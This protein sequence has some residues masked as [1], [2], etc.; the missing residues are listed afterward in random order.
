MKNLAQGYNKKSILIISV[1]FL[2]GLVGFITVS[3]N[4]ELL[5]LFCLGCL[6]ILIAVRPFFGLI[7]SIPLVMWFSYT[8]LLWISAWNYILAFLIYLCI[9]ILVKKQKIIISKYSQRILLLFILF[10]FLT[11]I[12]NWTNGISFNSTILIAAKL[13]S[14][15]LL[16]FCTM[17]FIKNEKQLKFFLY[18]L[19][20]CMSISALVGIGQFLDIDFFW[21]IREILGV[22]EKLISKGFLTR[23]RISGLALYSISFGYMLTSVVPLIF[24][25]LINT[26]CES[27]FKKITLF[28][29]FILCFSALLF[30]LNRS[31]I[32]GGIIGIVLIILMTWSSIK[33][34][35]LILL[36]VIFIFLVLMLNILIGEIIENR[37]LF[38]KIK[39]DLLPRGL[40]I[41]R[42][43]DVFF[44]HPFGIGRGNPNYM[45]YM[46]DSGIYF[47][48]YVK[49]YNE[50]GMISPHN[51]FIN[52]LIYYGFL[53]LFLLILFYYY[54]FNGMFYIYHN[55][56][57]TFIRG[58][59]I[60]LIGSFSAYII[61]SMFHNNGPFLVDPF[62]W[63]FIGIVMF[64]LNNYGNLL[65]DKR[66]K[67]ES[68]KD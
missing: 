37:F 35:K 18:F 58:V 1:I 44:N 23:S 7:L 46:E 63:Y 51:Q 60:G 33:L 41:L 66:R 10:I 22:S 25:V 29:T 45:D 32:L 9:L 12:I 59:N 54:I 14:T 65:Y 61:N 17:F 48:R 5:I 34:R 13:F 8:D 20:G 43:V 6:A 67:Y 2:A 47:E 24:S 38:S 68:A 49:K 52:I 21:K 53:G 36:M 30:T 50:I 27:F 64:L 55:N 40:S 3:G 4:M 57:N 39:M 28:L 62:N 31:A 19:I 56:D 15:L 26:K 16:A 11:I 42:A